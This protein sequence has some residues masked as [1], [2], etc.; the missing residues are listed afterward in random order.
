MWGQLCLLDWKT[1]TK[2]RSTV[3][4]S[5]GICYSRC[6]NFS[7]WMFFFGKKR[8]FP[9]CCGKTTKLPLKNPRP[10]GGVDL[11]RPSTIPITPGSNER[12]HFDWMSMLRLHA[13]ARHLVK[14][15]GCGKFQQGQPG[16]DVTV[17]VSERDE[18]GI[19]GQLG[20]QF[21]DNF[22]RIMMGNVS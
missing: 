16:A 8:A 6:F 18:L 12:L 17:S 14:P 5:L 4:P 9:R 1:A 20:F 15:A 7:C 2:P 19:L 3:K 22:G 11:H 13:N 21:W 10:L